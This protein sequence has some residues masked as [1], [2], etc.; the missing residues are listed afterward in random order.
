VQHTG[1]FEGVAGG[2][3][4]RFWHPCLL[5]NGKYRPT[6]PNDYGP[7]L[8]NAF[9]IDFIR[10]NREKPFCLYYTMPLTHSPFEETP[11]PQQPGK[12]RPEGYQSNVEYLDHLMGQLLDAIAAAG[13]AENTVF[14]FVGDNGTQG[15]G[16]GSLT[17]MGVRVPLIV[18]YPGK[19]KSDVVSRELVSVVD[20]FPTVMELAGAELPKGHV[21]DGKSVVP[22]LQGEKTKHRDWLFSYLGTGR[23]LRDERFVLEVP[24]GNQPQR[25]LDAGDSRSGSGYQDVSKSTDPEI[26]KARERFTA[27]LK[28][29]PGPEGHPGLKP[30]PAGGK[31]KKGKGKNKAKKAA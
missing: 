29:L 21:L 11:N 22:T 14:I 7:D 5:E 8:M 24:G 2:R 1:R 6:Q 26:V 13:V 15:R 10:A 18:R 9:A 28:D 30:P 4:A 19:V 3:T 20:I 12:R 16:K 27:I 17:E 25:L 23:I 31:A